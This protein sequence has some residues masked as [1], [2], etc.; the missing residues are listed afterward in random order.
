MNIISEERRMAEKHHPKVLIAG[1]TG[2]GKT[3]LLRTLPHLERVLFIDIEAG[4]L[5]VQDV[6]VAALRPDEGQSWTWQDLRNIACYLGGPDLSLPEG[7]PYGVKH[8]ETMVQR[9][10]DE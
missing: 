9:F 10:N 4:D 8:Y 7:A 2:I 3:S 6:P 1:P 5:A